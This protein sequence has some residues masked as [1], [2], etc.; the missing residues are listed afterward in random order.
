MKNNYKVL[1]VILLV[2]AV[3]TYFV[4]SHK[5]ASTSHEN[6]SVFLVPQLQDKI[7]DV[8]SIK[9]SKNARSV[10]LSK[11]SGSWQIAE[12]QGY[13]ADANKVASLLLDLRKF[14]LKERKTSNP[15][16][17]SHLSLTDSGEK[18]ATKIEIYHD[19][20]AFAV[21]YLGKQSQ[22]GQG[23]YV[24]KEGDKQ[25]WLTEGTI[26]VNLDSKNWIVNSILD[27]ASQSIK[28]VK[29]K[30]SDGKAFSINKITPKD[31]EFVLQGLEQGLQVKSGVDI[32]SFANGLQNLNIES[33][34]KISE[35]GEMQATEEIDYQLFSGLIYKLSLYEKEDKKWLTVQLQNDSTASAFEK[36]LQNWLFVI[37][38][39]KYDALNKKLADITE[40]A[41]SEK[42]ETKVSSEIKSEK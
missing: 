8:D 1:F 40:K 6:D 39:F 33:A 42:P 5:K 11:D 28:S 25:S 36:Q 34:S 13:L 29:F 17:Y 41:V 4:V 14:K 12:E 2:L 31:T 37:P 18:A 19:K 16:N 9:I 7:N 38:K 24:R 21:I 35:R 27:V 15:E 10:T 3:L 23:T 20:E 30:P 22:K 32:S 26:N